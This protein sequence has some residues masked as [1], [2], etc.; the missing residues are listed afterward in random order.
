MTNETPM[1]AAVAI[2][3]SYRPPSGFTRPVLSRRMPD[4]SFALEEN[5]HTTP[6]GGHRADAAAVA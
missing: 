6:A 5:S 1:N 2:D 3:K 4:D